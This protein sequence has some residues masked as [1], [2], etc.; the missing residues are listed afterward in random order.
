MK[1]DFKQHL[2]DLESELNKIKSII[3]NTKERRK[4]EKALKNKDIQEVRID[5]FKR[6]Y[7]LAYKEIKNQKKISYSSQ[8][9]EETGRQTTIEN[10]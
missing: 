10:I 4:Y 7:N 6:G 1:K 9:K 5:F 2:K 8:T 3:R